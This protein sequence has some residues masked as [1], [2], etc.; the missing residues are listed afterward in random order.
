MLYRCHIRPYSRKNS[1]S[2]NRL[3]ID[4]MQHVITY[5]GVLSTWILW[6]YQVLY[7]EIFYSQPPIARTNPGLGTKHHSHIIS[8]GSNWGHFTKMVGSEKHDP[9]TSHENYPSFRMSFDIELKFCHVKVEFPKVCGW[10]F[11]SAK[12]QQQIFFQ[13]T[14]ITTGCS[15]SSSEEFNLGFRS[16]TWEDQ[17]L[18]TENQVVGR[19]FCLFGMAYF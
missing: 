14:T 2:G 6:T 4:S 8:T 12:V 19:W 3:H 11:Q 16:C 17:Q 18:A 9:N 10:G 1:G 13:T 7:G 5:L 15:H